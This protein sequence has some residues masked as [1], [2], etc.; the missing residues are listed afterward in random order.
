MPRLPSQVRARSQPGLLRRILREKTW[1]I[2]ETWDYIYT[3]WVYMW[4]DCIV[5]IYI[6][7]Y[8]VYLISI[9]SIYMLHIYIYT[10]WLN[11][12]TCNNHYNI[13]NT[14]II[15]IALCN[16]RMRLKDMKSS[17]DIRAPLRYL[18]QWVPPGTSAGQGN[19]DLPRSEL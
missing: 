15:H 5:H 14:Y 7:I 6:Y 3:Y 4:F 1:S 17:W 13:H 9:K 16:W 19:H 18:H 8:T 12:V 2:L 10:Y 11:N